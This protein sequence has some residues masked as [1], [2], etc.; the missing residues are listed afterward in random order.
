MR[1]TCVVCLS[2]TTV[3]RIVDLIRADPE[4]GR[5]SLSSW[6]EV[7]PS[8]YEAGE[9]VRWLLEQGIVPFAGTPTARAVLRA[10]RIAEASFLST[11]EAS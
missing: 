7:S 1:P 3:E 6:E 11:K 4:L 9:R 10:L 2:D 5:G 8:D